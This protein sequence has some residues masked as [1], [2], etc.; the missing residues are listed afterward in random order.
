MSET[1][2]DIQGV[3][4]EGELVLVKIP[5]CLLCFTRAEWIGA[6]RRGKT[7]LRNRAMRAREAKALDATVRLPR[8]S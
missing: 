5:R 8:F 6:I 3:T 1:E 4:Y 2:N 7:V